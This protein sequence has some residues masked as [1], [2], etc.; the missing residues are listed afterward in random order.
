MCLTQCKRCGECMTSS[1]LDCK[2]LSECFGGL[3]LASLDLR[4]GQNTIDFMFGRQRLRAY[5]YFLHW[6]TRCACAYCSNSCLRGRKQL[7]SLGLSLLSA[8]QSSMES[9][10]C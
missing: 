6:H 3:Q 4:D 5:I 1:A 9:P 7:G 2:R 8:A 10:R